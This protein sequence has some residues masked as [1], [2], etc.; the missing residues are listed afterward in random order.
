[1]PEL[2]K[3]PVVGRWVII[4]TERARRPTDFQREPVRPRGTSC[5]FCAGTED[6][7]PPEILAGR[8]DASPTNGPGWTYRVVANK[9][10]ALRIEGDP[11]SHPVWRDLR[12]DCRARSAAR[13]RS[14]TCIAVL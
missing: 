8:P 1:M 7:T 4:S 12:S 14:C 2:R 3:D 13:T 9:F 5:V 11:R 10:P 6:K